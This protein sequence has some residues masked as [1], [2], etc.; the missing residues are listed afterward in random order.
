M[1]KIRSRR[2]AKLCPAYSRPMPSSAAA[3]YSTLKGLDP[4]REN[5]AMSVSNCL[6]C[7]FFHAPHRASRVYRQSTASDKHKT[8]FPPQCGPNHG[9]FFQE[10]VIGRITLDREVVTREQGVVIKCSS[11][12]STGLAIFRSMVMCNTHVSKDDKAPVDTE[13][14]LLNFILVGRLALHFDGTSHFLRHTRRN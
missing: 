13:R 3:M 8:I 1:R 7:P 12:L 4:L 9:I 14:E 5:R 11:E 6:Y 10:E 2:C